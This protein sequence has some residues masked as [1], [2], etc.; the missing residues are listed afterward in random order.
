MNRFLLS[1]FCFILF[2]ATNYAQY[3]NIINS[4]KPGHTETPYALGTNVIQFENTILYN[5]L[6]SQNIKSNSFS[7]DFNLRIGFWKE[8]LEASLDHKFT[9]QNFTGTNRNITG[10]EMLSVGLKY[11]IY[12]HITKESAEVK[13]SWKRRYG[14]KYN[15]LIPSVAAKFE[16]NS[17]LT[18]LNFNNGGRTTFSTSII[19]QNHINKR[20]RVNNQLDYKYIGGDFPEFIYTLSSSYVM[21][22][23]FNPYAEVRYHQVNDFNFFNVGIGTPFLVNKDLSVAVHMNAAL[24]KNTLGSEFGINASYRIDNHYDRWEYIDLPEE[25]EPQPTIRKKVEK[26]EEE[27]VDEILIEEKNKTKDEILD[28]YFRQQ[29]EAIRKQEEKDRK[30]E[31]ARLKREEKE[32]KKK[33]KER[34]RRKKRKVKKKEMD[35]VILSY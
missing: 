9:T 20:V 10:T 8:K 19:A 34:K 18:N 16:I 11:L 33:E 3:T 23:R 5:T 4:N 7:N 28:E 29:D 13:K 12:Q 24:G 2:T 31:E 21:A 22:K 35:D 30:E 17:P 15:G 32:N 25:E 27:F 1:F 6:D 14:F 26:K